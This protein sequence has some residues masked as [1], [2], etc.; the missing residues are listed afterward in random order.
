MEEVKEP[1]VVELISTPREMED[2]IM[3]PGWA[4]IKSQLL[5][6]LEDIRDSLEDQD[7][8]LLDKTL[9]RL[10]GNAELL[11]RVIALP[12]VTLANLTEGIKEV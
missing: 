3:S 4:D 9:H 8:I 10:G 12:S 5:A 6:W 11:R 2:F 1:R 7:N